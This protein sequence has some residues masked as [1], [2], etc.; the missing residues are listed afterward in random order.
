MIE[1]ERQQNL[2]GGYAIYSV[3]R[4][5]GKQYRVE[6]GQVIEV[7][8]L[9]AEVGSTVELNDVLLV[10]DN[11]DVRVGTPTVE[12]ARVVAEVLE[13]GR[14][15]KLLVFKYK[16]KTRYRRKRGHRQGYTRLAIR[17]IVTGPEAEAQEPAVEQ[18][19][20]KRARAVAAKPKVA[21]K[22]SAADV[23]VEAA[24]RQRRGGAKAAE[25]AAPASEVEI[26]QPA[27]QPKAV[28]RPRAKPAPPARPERESE[29][30]SQ[31]SE[32]PKAPRRRSK[33]AESD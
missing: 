15:K 4:S 31:E 3:V 23:A 8:K 11:G 32:A 12:G 27:A 25:A 18:T 29:A 33:K 30:A 6:P 10:A 24:P 21:A 16:A 13:H 22:A 17:R 2:S 19:K 26:A 14:G 7:D 20:P 28:R 1:F 5:G 9:P